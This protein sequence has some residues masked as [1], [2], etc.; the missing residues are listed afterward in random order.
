MK[1]NKKVFYFVE[2]MLDAVVAVYYGTGKQCLS[3]ISR[4]YPTADFTMK[5]FADGYAKAITITADGIPCL[6]LIWLG[7]AKSLCNLSHECDHTAFNILSDRGILVTP[8]EHETHAYLTGWLISEIYA[9]V[10][11]TSQNK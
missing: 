8:D 6:Y 1:A 9:A 7:P 11:S 2:E 5:D 3:W 10:F 4:K